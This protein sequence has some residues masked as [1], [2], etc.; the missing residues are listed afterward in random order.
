MASEK[1]Y[2]IEQ[3]VNTHFYIHRYSLPATSNPSIGTSMTT[4]PGLSA[5][6][7]SGA[8]YMFRAFVGINIATSGGTLAY[9]FSASGGLTAT[10]I[11]AF[12]IEVA[13]TNVTASATVSSLGGN[14]A[15]STVG[16]TVDRFV[17]FEGGIAVNVGGTMNLQASLSSGSASFYRF[18]TYL[19]ITQIT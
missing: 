5:V 15:G 12:M 1:E 14:L 4:V 19:D 6:L 17:T 13:G 11:R 3:R 10:T 16:S 2:D 8:T 9:Q 7:D 18:G